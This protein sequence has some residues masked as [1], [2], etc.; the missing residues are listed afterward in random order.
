MSYQKFCRQHKQ[1]PVT[2]DAAPNMQCSFR[3]ATLN[4]S[5]HFKL[6]ILIVMLYIITSIFIVFNL[7]ILSDGFL[8]KMLA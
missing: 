5:F 1:D 4:G 7:L 6:L 8:N 3:P 2:G